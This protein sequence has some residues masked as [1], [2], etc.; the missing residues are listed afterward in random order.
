VRREV[1]RDDNDESLEEILARL[2]RGAGVPNLDLPTTVREWSREPFVDTQKELAD[3]GI[4]RKG[5]TV[6]LSDDAPHA[7]IRKAIAAKR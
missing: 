1:P 3:L 5:D 6:I 2:N 4:T 7:A